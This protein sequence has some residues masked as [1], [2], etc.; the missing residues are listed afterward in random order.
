MCSRPCILGFLQI[1]N[2][3]KVSAVKLLQYVIDN[4]NLKG[5][6]FLY[7]CVDIYYL[8]D[9]TLQRLPFGVHVTQEIF[10]TV[11]FSDIFGALLVQGLRVYKRCKMRSSES[12]W[13]FVSR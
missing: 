9:M 13:S 10:L 3:K 8:H 6:S 5:F 4:L 1:I 2:S 7:A 11:D 12:V